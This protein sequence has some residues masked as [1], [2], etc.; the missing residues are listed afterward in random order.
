M[1][2]AAISAH[3]GGSGHDAADGSAKPHES[4][5]A[6]A[7]SGADYVEI[8][9]R[10]TRDGVLVDYHDEL[11]G[12]DGRAVADL[13]YGR[14]CELLGYAV[15]LAAEA[16]GVL[17][18]KAAC[19]LDLKGAGYEAPAVKLALDAFGPDAFVV[20]TLEDASIARIRREFPE[21]RTALALGGDL[22]GLRPDRRVAARL[23]DVFPIRRLRACGAH[24]AAL[25]YRLVHAGVLRRCAAHG[26]GTMLWTVDRDELIA[27]FLSD[28]R[29]EVVITNCPARARALRD[30]LGEA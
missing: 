14:M 5:R 18:G 1:S 10:Q 27:K 6:A 19:H 21:V 17:A 8:D 24:W 16:M 12:P 26:I 9:I 23:G 15:P 4:Y 22:Q 7:E 30:R 3:R 2:R 29:V 13:G 20:T 11:C 25:N 28:P